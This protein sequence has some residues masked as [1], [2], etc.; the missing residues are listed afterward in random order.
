VAARSP[1]H[2][3]SSIARAGSPRLSAAAEPSDHGG[4]EPPLPSSS[5]R[6]AERSPSSSRLSDEEDGRSSSERATS[7][8]GSGGSALLEES[9]FSVNTILKQLESIQQGTPKNIVILGTRHCSFLHQ[10]II[11][12]LSCAAPHPSYAGR[13]RT[14]AGRATG[15]PAGLAAEG[16]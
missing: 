8:G 5:R 13:V 15:T 3:V 14:V 6:A 12:L 9:D 16:L 7:G 11:E 1:L 2:S 10:Q 4:G